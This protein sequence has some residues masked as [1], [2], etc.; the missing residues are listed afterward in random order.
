MIL[1]L[2]IMIFFSTANKIHQVNH[3]AFTTLSLKIKLCQH[4][5]KLKT[6]QSKSIKLNL[7][8]KVPENLIT[9]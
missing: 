4:A 1:K 8:K 3:L 7:K 2:F 5:Q 9:D 6:T